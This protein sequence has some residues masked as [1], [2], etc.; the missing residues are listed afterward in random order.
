LYKLTAESKQG[1]LNIPLENLIREKI[2]EIDKINNLSIIHS[3][4][5][6]DSYKL[7]KE[8]MSVGL[9]YRGML[10][11][12]TVFLGKPL[13]LCARGMY[14]NNGLAF[15]PKSK[16]DYFSLFND[17]D[18]LISGW[19][20]NYRRNI[21][22]KLCRWYMFEV[23]MTFPSLSNDIIDSVIDL[24]LV[25]NDNIDL[26]NNINFKKLVSYLM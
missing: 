20:E 23:S 6:V 13:I 8:K 4:Q 3:T 5:Y 26:K 15:E 16:K 11:L 12:E 25:N 22:I 17:V 14:S 10:A 21:A 19:D 9:I 7:I 2:P 18:E 1:N 24:Y